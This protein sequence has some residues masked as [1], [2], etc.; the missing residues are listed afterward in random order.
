MP[1]TCKRC[2]PFA[3]ALQ[4]ACPT[5]LTSPELH[6]CLAHPSLQPLVRTLKSSTARGRTGA[7]KAVSC[8]V[9]ECGCVTTPAPLPRDLTFLF[10]CSR[11]ILGGKGVGSQGDGT[12]QLLCASREAQAEA[13]RI[14]REELRM[15]PM[16]LSLTGPAR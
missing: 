6:R 3:Q 9:P 2:G 7:K 16:A 1:M 4:P 15:V 10:F 12:A 11:Q 8:V 14:V 5:Q 13:V